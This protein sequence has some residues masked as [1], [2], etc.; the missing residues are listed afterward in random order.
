[1][2][3]NERKITNFMH[4]LLIL[5]LFEYLW[6]FNLKIDQ[7]DSFFNDT[8]IVTQ[9]DSKRIMNNAIDNYISTFFL[10]RTK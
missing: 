10:E 4:K 6:G 2:L 9:W 5:S 1:M 3:Q 7:Q 8:R